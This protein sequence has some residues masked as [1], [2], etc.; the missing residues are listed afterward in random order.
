MPSCGQRGVGCAALVPE[1]ARDGLEVYAAGQQFSRRVVPWCVK[2][3]APQF[4]PNRQPPIPLC[5]GIWPCIALRWLTVRSQETDRVRVQR[6]LTL[7]VT[8]GRFSF[9]SLGLS[10]L[11]H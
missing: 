2:S 10:L 6:E 9:R 4:V 3:G 5:H 8:F 7:L 11:R 1:P